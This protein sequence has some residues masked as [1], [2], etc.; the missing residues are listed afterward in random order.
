VSDTTDTPRDALFDALDRC[1]AGMLGVTGSGAHMR[2][3]T[4]FADRDS[5]RLWFLTSR[6]TDLA[7][8]MGA[9]AQAMHCVMDE[10]NGFHACIA[11]SI[12]ESRDQAKID[13]VW[14]PMTAAWFEGREDPDILLVEF[15]PR[16]AEIWRSTDSTIRFGLEMLRA[17]LDRDK[18]PDLGS[19]DVVRF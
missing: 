19:H 1:R 10:K 15:T 17:N 14:S 4:H 16:E 18:Q 13:E 12:R 3:M 2:P 7:E 5:G 6:K 9:Q 11:G 8:Q